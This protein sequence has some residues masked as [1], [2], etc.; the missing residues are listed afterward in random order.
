MEVL[1]GDVVGLV[2]VKWLFDVFGKWWEGKGGRVLGVFLGTGGTVGATAWA[3]G[4]MG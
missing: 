3:V 2:Y 1:K 4:A